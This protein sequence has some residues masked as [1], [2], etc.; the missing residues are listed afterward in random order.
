M[1]FNLKILKNDQ[2]AHFDGEIAFPF[3]N[4]DLMELNYSGWKFWWGD[5][6]HNDFFTTQNALVYKHNL[7]DRHLDFILYQDWTNNTQLLSTGN[8]NE[9]LYAAFE[10][11]YSNKKQHIFKVLYGAY[12]AGIRC[13]GGQCRTLPGFEGLQIS[14]SAPLS[15][16]S[17]VK[18]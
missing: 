2:L 15:K 6:Q 4:G 7:E 9:N 5:N 1:G 13:S 8:I 14:Y 3:P 11:V 17:S 12:K 16:M 10:V 18:N